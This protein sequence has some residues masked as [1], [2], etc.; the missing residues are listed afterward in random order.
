MLFIII[1]LVS[2]IVAKTWEELE[3]MQPVVLKMIKK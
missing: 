3:K 1:R 2:D